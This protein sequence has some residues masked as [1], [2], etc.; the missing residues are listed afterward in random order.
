M[1]KTGVVGMKMIKALSKSADQMGTTVNDILKK[2]QETNAQQRQ[3]K[4]KLRLQSGL[5]DPRERK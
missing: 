2:T 4:D 1:E 5:R 3:L